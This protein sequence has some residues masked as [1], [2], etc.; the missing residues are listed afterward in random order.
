MNRSERLYQQE[1][2]DSD[3]W[4][5]NI[6]TYLGKR[7][8]V[9]ILSREIDHP[10]SNHPLRAQA[11]RTMQSFRSIE[12]TKA[13]QLLLSGIG[14]SQDGQQIKAAQFL[15]SH[16]NL[17]KIEPKKLKDAFSSAVTERTPINNIRAVIQTGEIIAPHL[18]NNSTREDLYQGLNSIK[19][20]LPKDKARMADINH[21]IMSVISL[22]YGRTSS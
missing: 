11:E 21:E 7:S 13:A 8:H 1:D 9:E 20:K 19:D 14:K 15:F 6:Q 17:L 4:I 3:R 5:K 2:P 16:L 12:T 18:T 10:E 22:I